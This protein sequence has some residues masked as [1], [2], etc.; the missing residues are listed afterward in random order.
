[1]LVRS[2]RAFACVC[3]VLMVLAGCASVSY[4]PGRGLDT[5]SLN[6]ALVT[7]DVYAIRSAIQAGVISPNQRIA[8]PGYPD[9][10]PLLAIAARAAGGEKRQHEEGCTGKVHGGLAPSIAQ[11]QVACYDAPL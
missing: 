10:A 1:M 7:D 3:V 2:V 6:N 9:G 8:T 11:A 4:A 5:D